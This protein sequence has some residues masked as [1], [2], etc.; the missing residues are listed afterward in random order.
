MFSVRLKKPDNSRL[1]Q[2]DNR[3][4][5]GGLHRAPRE[6]KWGRPS[7]GRGAGCVAR[8][9]RCGVEELG[10]GGGA[11]SQDR[12]HRE[13]SVVAVTPI[14]VARVGTPCT[15]LGVMTPPHAAVARWAA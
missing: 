10:D 15:T 1:D 6:P 12:G 2:C 4:S 3:V 8:A 11:S 7:A 5:R 14:D 13:S 9:G